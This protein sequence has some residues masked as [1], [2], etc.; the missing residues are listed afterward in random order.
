[1]T[2]TTIEIIIAVAVVAVL[3]IAGI[4]IWAL[5]RRRHRTQLREHFG[6]EYEHAVQSTGDERKA[7]AELEERQKRVGA[8][9]IQPLSIVQRDRYM[10]QWC[11]IQTNFVDDPRQAIV[12]ADQLIQEVMQLRGY[13]VS[14]FEQQAG[15]LSV[16]HPK[17]VSNYRAA[18][19]I[20]ER[21]A[22]GQ[23]DTEE[24]RQAM[25]YYR[26]LFEDLVEAQSEEEKPELQE[27]AK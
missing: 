21:S 25:V 9:E 11:A 10:S 5:A 27:A 13:P 1:M 17:V 26:S 2:T 7:I 23:A 18:H 20:A 12:G 6:P 15:D 8:M 19:E 4:L 22:Q 24:L 14:D 3:V 16:N